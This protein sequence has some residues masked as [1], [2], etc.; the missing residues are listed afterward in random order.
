MN[1]PPGKASV[2]K[3]SDG[4]VCPEGTR[5]LPAK[6]RAC[7]EMFEAH[8]A[9]CYYDVRYEWWASRRGWFIVI[10]ELAGGGGVAINYCPHCSSRLAGRLHSGRSIDLPK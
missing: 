8:T 10:P 2:R 4:S 9:A 3:H 6:F 5:R 1:E 7:C